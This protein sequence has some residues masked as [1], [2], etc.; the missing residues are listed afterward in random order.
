MWLSAAGIRCPEGCPE[1]EGRGGG[2]GGGGG[3]WLV[4]YHVND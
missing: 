2:G 4:H 3:R 1:G